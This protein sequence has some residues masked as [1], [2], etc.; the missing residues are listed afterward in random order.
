VAVSG[1]HGWRRRRLRALG[2]GFGERKSEKHVLS[3]CYH[4]Y[5][6]ARLP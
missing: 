1:G 2:K 4:I 6:P 5:N 3:R